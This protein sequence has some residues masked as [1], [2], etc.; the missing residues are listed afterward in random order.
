MLEANE[1]IL[2]SKGQVLSSSEEPL[3]YGEKN[4]I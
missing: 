4:Y 2:I 3:P 1:N